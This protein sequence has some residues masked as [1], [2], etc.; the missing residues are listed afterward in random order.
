M[1]RRAE[2]STVASDRQSVRRESGLM[3]ARIEVHGA[4]LLADPTGAIYWPAA[5]L[6]AI[7]DLHL[8]KGSHFAARGQLLPPYDT[9]ATLQRLARVVRR[10]RPRRVACLGD[11]FHDQG[12]AARLDAADRGQLTRLVGAQDWIWI[13]GNHDPAPP[14]SLGGRVSGEL[15]EPPLVFRHAPHPDPAP[16][17]I[18]GH[19]HPKAAVATSARRVTG[20]CFVT[21]GTRLVLPAFGAYAGGLDALAPAVTRLFGRRGFRVL[22]VGRERLHL[23]PQSRLTPIAGTAM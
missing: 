22:L 21:D 15:V 1:V 4:A 16:G 3:Q 5:G 17:E 8:E 7:A 12:A 2:E 19:L 20:P 10:Y 14:P 18:A 11:S 23:F 13:A 9:R 6:L